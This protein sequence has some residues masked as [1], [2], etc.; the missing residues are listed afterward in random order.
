MTKENT[1]SHE[2]YVRDNNELTKYCLTIS[3]PESI[4][5]EH[6]CK[7]SLSPFLSNEKKIFGADQV[8]AETLSKDFV[9]ALLSGKVL[10]YGNGEEDFDVDNL[11]YRDK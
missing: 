6:F 9:R 8:Q 10:T 7:V 2:F 3:E 4:N 11:L 5:D 1:T